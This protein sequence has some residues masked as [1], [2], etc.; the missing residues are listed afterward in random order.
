MAIVTKTKPKQLLGNSERYHTEE[1]EACSRESS[2]PS[3]HAGAKSHL[4]FQT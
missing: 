4:G 1:R 3:Q 2:K